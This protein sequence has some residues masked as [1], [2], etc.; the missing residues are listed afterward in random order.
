MNPPTKLHAALLHQPTLIRFVPPPL[1]DGKVECDGLCDAPQ[2]KPIP[3]IRINRELRGVR[4]LDVL[5]HEMLHRLGWHIDE[6]FVAQG[7]EDMADV[8]WQLGYR[9]AWDV[10]R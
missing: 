7:A 5:I 2:R 9:G 10:E 6:D 3:R 4:M 8:L 1:M